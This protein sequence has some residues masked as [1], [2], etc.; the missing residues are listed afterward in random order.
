MVPSQKCLP[1]GYRKEQM[2]KNN[3]NRAGA[4]KSEEGARKYQILGKDTALLGKINRS[5]K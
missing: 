2:P 5:K 3:C 1:L 4:K